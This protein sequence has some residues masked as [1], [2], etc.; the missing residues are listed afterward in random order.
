[1]ASNCEGRLGVLCIVSIALLRKDE[2]NYRGI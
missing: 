1:M 2:S